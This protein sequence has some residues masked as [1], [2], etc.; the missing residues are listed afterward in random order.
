MSVYSI[1]DL[2]RL[3][4]IKAHT[5][6]IWEKRYE[7][8]S[9]QRTDT[10]IRKYSDDDVKLILRIHDLQ[11]LGYKISKIVAMSKNEIDN[12]LDNAMNENLG[13]EETFHLYVN[14]L[15]TAGLTFN[16]AK[17]DEVYEKAKSNF[18]IKDVFEKIFYV[19]LIKIGV[20]WSK[21]GAN[22]A[23]E[24]FLSCLIRQYIIS[25]TKNLPLPSID[26][27]FILFLPEEED[28]EIGLLFVQYWLKKWNKNVVYLG[29][30]VPFDNLFETMKEVPTKAIF[31]FVTIQSNLKYYKS[32][33]NRLEK[34]FSNVKSFWSGIGIPKDF[35]LPKLGNRISSINQLKELILT[36]Y[37]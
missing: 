1:K 3:S 12:V 31:S 5:I 25:E 35:D 21:G 9:P 6:R 33:K 30:R 26:E 22:P 23:Q 37:E 36:S 17:F 24:H 8:F 7:L 28:H 19:V 32:F 11:Q 29:A 34:D 14:E 20:L 16:E 13:L 18:E 2:E 4:D 27:T 10:N 15:L